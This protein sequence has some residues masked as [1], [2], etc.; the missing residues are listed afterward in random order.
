MH[1][2]EG[3]EEVLDT[4]N[5]SMIPSVQCNAALQGRAYGAVQ[6]HN[7]VGHEEGDRGEAL[8]WNVATGMLINWAFCIQ[9]TRWR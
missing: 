8:G 5:A 3:D 9:F 2:A 1:G 7:L 4:A 6:R